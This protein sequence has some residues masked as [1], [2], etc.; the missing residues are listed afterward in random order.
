MDEVSGLP[1]PIFGQL[2]LL[3]QGFVSQILSAVRMRIMRTWQILSPTGDLSCCTY[4]SE[5]AR[6]FGVSFLNK[7]ERRVKNENSTLLT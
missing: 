6:D 4:D 3:L 1:L 7:E 5:I 2:A